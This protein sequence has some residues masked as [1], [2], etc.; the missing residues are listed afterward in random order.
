MKDK[1]K[2]TGKT[3]PGGPPPLSQPAPTLQRLKVDPGGR[4]LVRDD[5]TPFFWLGDTAWFIM[6][7]SNDEIRHYLSNR[8]HKGFTGIQVDLNPYAWTKL[9]PEGEVDSPFLDDDPERPNERYWQRADWMVD[10]AARFGLYVLLTPMW[11][12][13]YP[14]Y[15]GADT[16]KAHR[17]GKWYGGRYRNRAH[18]MWFVS[19][20]YDAINGFRPITSAQRAIFNA[21]ARGLTEGH[22]GSQLM[23]I[24]PGV[25]RTSSVD[26][27]NEPWLDFNM[28]QSGHYDDAAKWG[29]LE[30]YMLIT[31]DRNRT[32]AKPVFE[33]EPTYE[34]IIDGYFQTRDES[35]TRM[36]ADVTR[37]KAYWSVFAG[38]FGHTYGHNDVQIFWSPGCPKEAA[39]RFYWRDALEAPGAG[40]MRHLRTLMESRSFLNRIPDQSVV[41]S[42]AGEGKDH[43]RG[44][45]ASDGA[46]AMVYI[47]TGRAVTVD[48]SKISGAGVKACWFDPRT[49]D[50]TATGD[51]PRSGTQVFDPPGE[52]AAGNDW[53]LVLDA[54]F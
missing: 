5:G 12:Q 46:Y 37:R 53:V 35:D 50:Y 28:L 33:G 13:H 36:G 9:V 3:M 47:P 24:H 30:T 22:G 19:G 42:D 16:E 51:Y 44:T 31:S 18:V 54:K 29:R 39:N 25:S 6:R 43:I 41:V 1:P 2:N 52:T 23:T 21:L 17:L 38:G 8:I 7:L 10:E 27:H 11:G 26:F 14:R 48:M 32:P 45:R 34:D 49:G 15:V 4:F 20:E 40:Q